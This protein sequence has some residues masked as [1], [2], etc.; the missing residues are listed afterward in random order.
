MGP[1]SVAVRDSRACFGRVGAH[2][3]RL[4]TSALLDLRGSRYIV[5]SKGRLP[6]FRQ[7]VNPPR[8]SPPVPL[9]DQFCPDS[10]PRSAVESAIGYSN[11][12]FV[13]DR[14]LDS[15]GLGDI[16]VSWP[17]CIVDQMV[18]MAGMPISLVGLITDSV[19]P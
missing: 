3:R 9:V 19:D 2:S 18:T 11:R 16:V 10:G 1:F 12:T 6:R 5:V 13:R 17:A 8:W 14:R 4:F 7:V 15:S